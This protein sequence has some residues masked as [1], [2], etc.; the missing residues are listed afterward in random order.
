MS[1]T[2]YLNNAILNLIFKPETGFPYDTPPYIGLSST[3]IDDNGSGVT[4]PEMGSATGYQ[5][6]SG[7]SIT[8]DFSVENQAKNITRVLFPMSITTWGTIVEVFLADSATEGNILYHTKL[9]PSIPTLSGTQIAINPG[10]LVVKEV[11]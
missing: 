9:T 8:W 5:R 10:T 6:I 3:L 1:A 2:T 4:E 7:S 11:V